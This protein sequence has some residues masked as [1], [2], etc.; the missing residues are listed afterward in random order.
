MGEPVSADHK[1]ILIENSNISG[2]LQ[3]ITTYIS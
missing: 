1:R 2:I 3:H